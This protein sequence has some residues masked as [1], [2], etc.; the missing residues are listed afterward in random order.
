MSSQHVAAP[1]PAG[2]GR[3]VYTL[4]PDDTGFGIEDVWPTIG[5]GPERV[6]EIRRKAERLPWASALLER[7]IAEANHVVENEEPLQPIER[8]GWRH[9]FYSKTTGEHLV[10]ERHQ[11]DAHLDPSTGERV[12]GPE[13]H[14]AWVLLTHE[15][16]HR[17]MRSLGLIAQLTGERRYAAWVREGLL[18]AVELFAHDELRE[19]NR[20]DALYFQPLYDAPALAQLCWSYA[21]TRDSSVYREGDHERI[22]IGIFERGIPYQL[23]FLDQIGVHNMACYVSMAVAVCGH[24]LGRADWLERGLRDPGVGLRGLLELGVPATPA[25]DADGFWYE[26]TTFYHWYS[27]C[28]LITLWELAQTL[29]DPLARDETVRRR[30]T[31]MLDAPVRMADFED[32]VPTLGDLGAPRVMTLDTYRHLYEWGAGRIDAVGL[33]AVAARLIERAGER[34]GWT[35]LAY[36]LDQ[37]RDPAP[38]LAEHTT[39]P[40]AGLVCFRDPERRMHALF[41]VG[42]HGA[43]H[44]HRDK[45][46]LAIHAYGECIAPDLGTPGYS[47]TDTRAYF[48]GTFS[49][50]TLMVDDKDQAE[51]H[52]VGLRHRLEGAPAY[53]EGVLFDAYP[54]VTL[55][56]RVWFDAPYVVVADDLVSDDEHRYA[57][58][59]HARGAFRA[60]VESPAEGPP[61]DHYLE[62]PPYVQLSHPERTG[63]RGRIEGRWRV[64]ERVGLRVLLRCDGLAE[65]ITGRTPGQPLH[66]DRGTLVVRCTGRRGRYV[67]VFEPHGG[68][69][70]AADIELRGERVQLTLT[71]GSVRRYEAPSAQH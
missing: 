3:R 18:R 31:A 62:S 36:G 6:P 68:R 2:G 33:G 64:A 13:E 55:T 52:N 19:G 26:G 37:L 51:V 59:F 54:G 57:W 25:G 35:A 67:A 9:Q 14:A 65:V 69:P 56:R 16:T 5:F 30:L 70:T 23:R 24:W 60:A 71:D 15:R 12:S 27:L 61:Y 47:L 10:Y 39:L 58:L 41:R 53:A 32:R 44:D 21:L 66:D 28:P 48:R 1:L 22:R 7:F 49:H 43:A 42:P 40:R 20:T 17:L 46:A 63:A 45:L 4:C 50:N 29:G 38:P 8:I 34:D 11:P